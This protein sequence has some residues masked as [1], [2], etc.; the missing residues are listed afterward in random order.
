MFRSFSLIESLIS[1]VII[2]ILITS[3][4]S[5]IDWNL[6]YQN[7]NAEVKAQVIAL[8]VI[9]NVKTS[10]NINESIATLNDKNISIKIMQLD[11]ALGHYLIQVSVNSIHNIEK[12]YT[13]EDMF[14]M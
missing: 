6:R 9:A 3:I 8:E 4:F 5:V 13:Y 11:N 14:S 7:F 2:S 10:H 1:T 12:V